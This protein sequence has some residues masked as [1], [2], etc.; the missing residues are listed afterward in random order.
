MAA[1]RDKGAMIAE[2]DGWQID[3][4]VQGYPGKSVCH[5]GLGWSTI[6]LLRGHER[7]ALVDVGSFSQ[8]S[9][10]ISQLAARGLTPAD[11]TDVLL[12]HSHWDH[13]INWV[14][15]PKARIA[16]GTKELAWS[17]KEPWGTTPVPELYVREL[18]R[19]KQTVLVKAGD[20]VLPGITAH[21]APGHTPGH[22]MFV[23][24]GR[25]RDVIFTG[26][27][28]KN[29]AEI[30]SLTADMSYDQAVSRAS[31]EKM[32]ELWRKKPNSIVVPG[33]DVPMLLD[34]GAPKYIGERAAAISSWFGDTLD[35]TKLFELTVR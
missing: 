13:A 25:D 35:Q 21:D 27:S 4:V 23:L 34:G 22:L 20:E 5:G 16:I 26:D 31:M 17:V 15:F 8:R 29:R 6:A 7:V 32:W 10:I 14:M 33:H 1:E 3:V 24:N 18:D 19:S 11:V 2:V 9:L 12:T 28:A 30:L